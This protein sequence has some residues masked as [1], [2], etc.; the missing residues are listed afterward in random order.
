MATNNNIKEELRIVCGIITILGIMLLSFEIAAAVPVE[1]WNRTFSVGLHG[2]DYIH[3]VKQTADGGYIMGGETYDPYPNN[4]DI[5]SAGW[6]KKTDNN[7]SVQWSEELKFIVYS[8]VKNVQQTMDGG[9][10]YG[11]SYGSNHWGEFVVKKIDTFGNVSNLYSKGLVYLFVHGYVQQT[12]DSGYIITEILVPP[13]PPFYDSSRL[14]K[15]DETGNEQWNKT[16]SDKLLLNVQ[17]T[18]DGGFII[19]TRSVGASPTQELMKTDAYGNILWNKSYNFKNVRQSTDGGYILIGSTTSSG[20]GG[21]DAWVIK[22]DALG[23]HLWNKTFGGTI[24]DYGED[25]QQTTEG[26]YIIAGWS[27]STGYTYAW[28]IK[29]DSSGN[30]QWKK[31]FGGNGYDYFKFVQQT[32]DGGYIAAGHTNSYGAGDYDAWL[33]KVKDVA[34]DSFG[35]NDASGSPGNTVSVPIVINNVMNGPIQTIIFNM[36][37]EE[38]VIL[39]DTVVTG[40]LT[41]SGW[42]PTVGTNKH[43][44]TLTT[45]NTVLAIPNGSTGIVGYLNFQV[46]GSPGSTSLMTPQNIDFSNTANQHGTAPAKIGTFSVTGCTYSISPTSQSFGDI[47]GSGSVSVTSPDDCSWTAT[48]NDAWITVTSGDSGSGS[49]TVGYS[50]AANPDASSR[51]GTMTIAGETFTVSQDGMTSN[52]IIQNPGFEEHLHGCFIQTVEGLSVYHLLVLREVMLQILH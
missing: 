28:L 39:L 22:T 44:I 21:S 49:G 20:A 34:A 24:D 38:S 3:S 51:T 40:P 37:Y 1:E 17:Q 2:D 8:S 47:G 16:Y 6:L 19:P 18:A 4:P 12:I 26:G 45:F 23:N 33:V 13:I 11:I 36:D 14:I 42:M 43:S 50:A 32:T 15:I 41:S 48:S 30:Q 31:T 9:Y 5:S 46:V 52:N 10:V 25:I 29:T 7:G 35:V 27:G